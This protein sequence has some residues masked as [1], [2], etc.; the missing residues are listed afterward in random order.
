MGLRNHISA[1]ATLIAS[2]FGGKCPRF[3]VGPDGDGAQ[4][5]FS[6]LLGNSGGE[7]SFGHAS[8]FNIRHR[9]AGINSVK[10]KY[11][12]RNALA[13]QKMSHLNDIA[14]TV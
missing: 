4:Q 14:E 13:A 8:G 5:I 9:D 10:K 6:G 12:N 3:A 7:L 11:L 1:A 2:R